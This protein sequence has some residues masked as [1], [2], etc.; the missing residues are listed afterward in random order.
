MHLFNVERVH[1]CYLAKDLQRCFKYRP[2]SC[3]GQMCLDIITPVS[4]I[5]KSFKYVQLCN[6]LLWGKCKV[7]RVV[8]P[9]KVT[10]SMAN[11][12]EA[13]PVTEGWLTELSL[14]CGCFCARGGKGGERRTRNRDRGGQWDSN[15]VSRVE[16]TCLDN[17]R[18]LFQ[19]SRK[20]KE[21]LVTFLLNLRAGLLGYRALPVFVFECCLHSGVCSCCHRVPLPSWQGPPYSMLHCTWISCLP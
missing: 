1:R 21:R 20:R 2:L 12:V 15:W 13:K 10:V 18:L 3:G 4:L 9:H 17:I 16:G 14:L 6:R 5:T 7:L 8:L 19:R 11:T